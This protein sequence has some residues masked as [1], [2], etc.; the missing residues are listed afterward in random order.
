MTMAEKPI[1]VRNQRINPGDLPQI[2]EQIYEEYTQRKKRRGDLILGQPLAQVVLAHGEP[3]AARAPHQRDG[4]R[5]DAEPPFHRQPQRPEPEH[6]IGDPRRRGAQPA[7]QI[8]G[9]LESAGEKAWAYWSASNT[10]VDQLLVRKGDD[11]VIQYGWRLPLP[12]GM[13]ENLVAA[14]LNTYIA[15]RAGQ[16]E[17]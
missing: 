17:R 4:A 5:R 12:E 1:L 13:A 15:Q 9:G 6:R 8:G 11:I 3:I 7:E 10:P 16:E 2:G 14:H